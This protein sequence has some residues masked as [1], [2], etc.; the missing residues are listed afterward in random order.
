MLQSL[1][2]TPSMDGSR[3]VILKKLR[4]AR[5]VGWVTDGDRCQDRNPDGICYLIAPPQPP[6]GAAEGKRD[7]SSDQ[8]AQQSAEPSSNDQA[9]GQR[10]AR[11]VRRTLQD[12]RS[13]PPAW[14]VGGPDVRDV[15]ISDGVRGVFC[16]SG[17]LALG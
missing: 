3:S 5:Y 16:L 1:A 12:M 14:A 7:D 4:P 6:V 9:N 10:R 15:A 13:H 2:Q 8:G 11:C 17:S